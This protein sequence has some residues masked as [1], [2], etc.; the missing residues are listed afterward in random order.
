[1]ADQVLRQRSTIEATHS[2]TPEHFTSP[3]ERVGKLRPSK[4]ADHARVTSSPKGLCS[5][6]VGSG[7]GSES[8]S[9][10]QIERVLLEVSIY[11]TYG[12]ILMSE[13]GWIAGD[14]DSWQRWSPWRYCSRSLYGHQYANGKLLRA[15]L[16]SSLIRL[17]CSK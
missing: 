4:S 13:I 7:T 17:F 15:T 6:L 9:D 8:S 2:Q 3:S 5:A 14:L 10:E 1:M 12:P 16:L 11:R